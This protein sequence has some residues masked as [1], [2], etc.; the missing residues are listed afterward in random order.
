MLAQLNIFLTIFIKRIRMT[1]KNIKFV[2]NES[3]I[4]HNLHSDI[5]KLVTFNLIA[6]LSLKIYVYVSYFLSNLN[7]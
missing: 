2:L 7:F 6:S 5:L 3:K 1:D 4:Q